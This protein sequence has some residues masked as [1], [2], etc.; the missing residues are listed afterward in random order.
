MRAV[1]EKNGMASFMHIRERFKAASFGGIILLK[2]ETGNGI[3]LNWV[4]VVEY[5]HLR[6]ADS[7]FL[8]CNGDFSEMPE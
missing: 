4:K 6:F 1:V 5:I 7:Q 8:Y 3:G 2:Y